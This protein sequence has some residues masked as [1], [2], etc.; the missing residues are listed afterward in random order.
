M[1]KDWSKK[2]GEENAGNTISGPKDKRIDQTKDKGDRHRRTGGKAKMEMGWPSDEGRMIIGGPRR[3]RSGG[4]EQ[5]KGN[6]NDQEQDGKM[7]F[8]NWQVPVD[9]SDDRQKRM[10]TNWRGLCPEMDSV[11]PKMTIQIRKCLNIPNIKIQ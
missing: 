3:Q 7:T 8:R 9:E 2:D 4:P 10:A 11:K 6:Q 5:R 1:F